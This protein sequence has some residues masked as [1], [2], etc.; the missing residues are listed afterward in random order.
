[1]YMIE[2][3]L[4]ATRLMRF[5]LEHGHGRASDEDFG[6]S[7]HAWLAATFGDARPRPFRLLEG[8]SGLRLL[9]YTTAPLDTLA[10]QAQLFADPST[11]SVCCWSTAAAKEMPARWRT[12]RRL[13]F[14]VRACPV[15]RAEQER[16]V[17][18]V[19]VSRSATIGTPPPP[20]HEVYAGWLA[21]QVA[22]SG[23]AEVEPAGIRL[24]RFRRILS[25]RLAHGRN[26]ARH[27]SVE[28]PDALFSGDLTI[29]DSDAFTRLLARGIGRHRAFG[30]GMLLL[31]PPGLSD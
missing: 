18:L 10:D 19:A 21:R 29:G 11:L 4:D 25:Q 27:R 7:A 3:P 26:S 28:R 16:D 20:R 13:G 15:S 23:A 24:I 9:G 17:F 8:P 5:A 1:M 22:A 30:F 12:G 14:E 6:Y 2:L 31:K